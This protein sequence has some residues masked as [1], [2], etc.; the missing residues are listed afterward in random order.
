MKK[1][2]SLIVSPKSSYLLIRCK[3]CAT[4]RIVFS[5]STTAIKCDGCGE[6]LVVP[7]GGMASINADI[8]KRLD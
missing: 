5:N 1:S 7:S 4:E 8:V 3:K 6:E 2:K